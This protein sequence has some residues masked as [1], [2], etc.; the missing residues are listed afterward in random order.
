VTAAGT[1]L[2]IAHRGASAYELENSLAAFHAAVRLRADGIELDVHASTDGCL[3]VHH[4]ETIRP[5]LRIASL[6]AGSVR[7]LRLAN[8][9]P[10]PTLT[11]ALQAAGPL[12]VY[13]EVKALDQRHDASL[14]AT[15][16]AG[17][18]P[19]GYAVHS[20]DHRIIQ[21][22]GRIR[23]GLSR[24]VLSASY[25]LHPEE[26]LT[27]TGADALWQ[28]RS[29]VDRDLVDLMHKTNRRVIVWTVDRPDEM[30]WLA[31]LG[32][33]AVCTNVPDV[34]RRALDSRS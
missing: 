5:N 26:Q 6:A 33:D 21:R 3:F 34:A 29:L 14:L 8:D 24:G 25:P 17:P 30:R 10:I 32:A 31:R 20:F 13:V 11:D 19:R 18:N 16:D 4:D 12:A 22:L 23:P 2:V 9:E 1:P 27:D 15:L 28:E 7:S